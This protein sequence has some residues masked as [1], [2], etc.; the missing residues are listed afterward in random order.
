MSLHPGTRKHLKPD[1]RG[2][3]RIWTGEAV[4]IKDPTCARLARAAGANVASISPRDDQALA[5]TAA[6]LLSI[7]L[8]AP[9]A[10]IDVLDGTPADAPEYGMLER[11]ARDRGIKANFVAYRDVES[12][13]AEIAQDVTDRAENPGRP[14][15]FLVVHQLQRYRTLRRNED[16]FSFSGSDA[17]PSPDKLLAGIVREGPVAGVHV[18]V[19]CDT[20]ASLQRSFDRNAL[21]EFDWKVLFQISPADSSNLIDSPAASRL[22]T[23][24][25]L[26]H[27]EELGLLEKFRPYALS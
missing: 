25:G 14:R 12:R 16:D 22:G 6:F 11:F 26:L 24:R 19:M 21:R 5:T 23:N 27:S 4:A 18:L 17:P 10:T 8:E 20:L 15:R 1:P 3:V 9:D 7:H 13:L 2:N